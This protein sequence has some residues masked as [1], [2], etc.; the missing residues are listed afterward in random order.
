M[1]GLSGLVLIALLAPVAQAGLTD[2]L[3][4]G[5]HGVLHVFGVMTES[6][7]RL[8]MPS[9]D[10]TVDMGNIAT[11]DLQQAGDR[12]TPVAV[13]LRLRD[14]IRGAANN[15]DTQGNVSW[16]PNQ[17]A[18]SLTFVSEQDGANP[19]LVRAKGVNGMGLRLSD[20]AQRDMLLGQLAKPVFLTPG[21]DVLTYY[22]TPERTGAPLQS[23]A[24]FAN[25]NF[26]LSYE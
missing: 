19:Q 20:S 15:Q 13:Q 6:A 22:I 9:A 5:D 26:R 17:P 11:G 7:C 3:V 24:Y 1:C 14:C 12:G 21:S 10:Q 23:G 16:S 8:E 4:E 25:V 18:M 2:G